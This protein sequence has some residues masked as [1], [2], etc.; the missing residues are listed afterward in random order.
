MFPEEA[1]LENGRELAE[2]Q[3]EKT[4]VLLLSCSSFQ[5]EE[6]ATKCCSVEW[7]KQSTEIQNT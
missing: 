6:Y 7:K 5:Q 4:V 1:V 2:F 3:K